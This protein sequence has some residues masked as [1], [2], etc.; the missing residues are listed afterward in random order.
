MENIEKCELWQGDCL[1]LM[2]N[3]P[4][5]SVD[6]I[7]CDL[8]YGTTACKWD[9]IIP[10]DKLWEQYK[11]VIKIDGTI[12]LFGSQPFT[13]ELIHSNVKW[14]SHTWIWNKGSCGNPFLCKVQPL[15]IH[16]DVVVF[17]RP[18]NYDL[19]NFVELRNIFKNI[20]GKIGKKKKQI[21]EDLGQGLD[22]CFRFDSL[23]WGL[24]TE[25]NYNRMIAF[26][27]LKDIPEYK[28]LKEIYEKDFKG[29]NKVYNPQMVIKGK[30]IRK[31]YKGKNKEDGILGGAEQNTV[32]FNNVYYPKSI[33]EF[34]NRKE[35]KYHPTQKPVA[36]LEYLIKTYTN[37]NNIILDNCMGSGSCGVACI[38][39]NRRFIGIELDEG[40]F[41]IAKQR[42]DEA[43]KGGA[44]G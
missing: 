10:F 17:S 27:D 36:L 28:Y 35:K 1:E 31:G 26:Y 19:N 25:K 14:F 24:P 40:Y 11:R 8:P 23:Q 44:N 21:I 12:I 20:M 29:R 42:I 3:I 13:S 9:I 41:N 33:I 15:K 2:K 7:L 6:M 38:N 37:E 4:D 16:E 5:K 18:D 32:S 30:P 43:I 34:S 22:H 39:T